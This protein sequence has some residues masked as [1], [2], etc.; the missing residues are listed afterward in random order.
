HG[1][2]T[3]EDVW[4]A[5]A[6]TGTALQWLGELKDTI[7]AGRPAVTRLVRPEVN[8]LLRVS[9]HLWLWNNSYFLVSDDGATMMVDCQ[10]TLPPAVGKQYAEAIGRPIEVVRVTHIHSD[11]VEGIEPL[12]ALGKATDAGF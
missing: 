4:P 11:H 5:L 8:R 3:D 7:C 9:K 1:P 2:V 6:R 12:R 10:G